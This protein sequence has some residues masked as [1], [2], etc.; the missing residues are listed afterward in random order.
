[1]SRIEIKAS[2][3]AFRIRNNGCLIRRWTLSHANES[4]V[5]FV[6][7]LVSSNRYATST[8]T[9][10]W[11]H[12]LQSALCIQ[13]HQKSNLTKTQSISSRKLK[14]FQYA[15]NR[16]FIA[17]IGFKNGNSYYVQC[18]ISVLLN[19]LDY[20]CCNSKRKKNRLLKHQKRFCSHCFHFYY[21]HKC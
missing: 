10:K 7:F 11:T 13:S 18:K 15:R 8:C 1:M 4:L 6:C 20:P 19:R 12:L 17:R 21:L 16:V 9:W 3:G 5:E 2:K 14:Y